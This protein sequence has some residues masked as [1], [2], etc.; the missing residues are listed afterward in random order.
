[1]DHVDV[2]IGV[3]GDAR[4]KA[5]EHY[6]KTSVLVDKMWLGLDAFK[7]FSNILKRQVIV[8]DLSGNT[9]DKEVPGKIVFDPVDGTSSDVPVGVAFRYD[10]HYDAVDNANSGTPALPPLVFEKVLAPSAGVTVAC[11]QVEHEKSTT[12]T[13]GASL[14]KVLD[15]VWPHLILRIAVPVPLPEL[16]VPFEDSTV[17]CTVVECALKTPARAVIRSCDDV[18]DAIPGLP[19]QVVPAVSPKR[20]AKNQKRKQRRIASAASLL[21]K[22]RLAVA[23]SEELALLQ[24]HRIPC[25]QIQA[26]VRRALTRTRLS[27]LR[28]AVTRTQT[29]FRRVKACTYVHNIREWRYELFRLPH[30]IKVQR[31]LRCKITLSLQ[32]RHASCIEIQSLTR[33]VLASLYLQKMICA[34]IRVQTL[35]RRIK[36]CAIVLSKRQR[37]HGCICKVQRFMR[38]KLYMLKMESLAIRMQAVVRGALFRKANGLSGNCTLAEVLS[39]FTP[40]DDTNVAQTLAL[41]HIFLRTQRMFSISKTL[42][43]RSISTPPSTN[44]TN[45]PEKDKHIRELKFLF[46]ELEDIVGKSSLL[47]RFD[48]MKYIRDV[49]SPDDMISSTYRKLMLKIHPDSLLGAFLRAGIR[50]MDQPLYN[51]NNVSSPNQILQDLCSALGMLRD[52]ALCVGFRADVET[53]HF[54]YITAVTTAVRTGVVSNCSS[55]SDICIHVARAVK[56]EA[57]V[58]VTNGILEIFEPLDLDTI[59]VATSTSMATALEPMLRV[60]RAGPAQFYYLRIFDSSIDIYLA[61]VS[62]ISIT[63]FNIITQS[64]TTVVIIDLGIKHLL[65]GGM[66]PA[67]REIAKCYKRPRLECPTAPL[68]AHQSSQPGD[69]IWLEWRNRDHFFGNHLCDNDNYDCDD[70][71]SF[72]HNVTDS[73][74]DNDNYDD[75]VDGDIMSNDDT[76]DMSDYDSPD[77]TEIPGEVPCP[78]SSESSSAPVTTGKVWEWAFSSDV[79]VSLKNVLDTVN[80]DIGTDNATVN[81]D[82]DDCVSAGTRVST[83]TYCNDDYSDG[84]DADSNYDAIGSDIGA[85]TVPTVNALI[86][87]SGVTVS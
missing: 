48:P 34:A 42:G 32:K 73:N 20:F 52:F 1:M 81:D 84:R 46:R 63:V 23:V 9:C 40:G 85:V 19:L 29:F 37:R 28:H 69:V 83:H 2:C 35:I 11:A 39:K 44:N 14:P 67:G 10:N 60:L 5:Y 65:R 55:S 43:R 13:G 78:F 3:V 12:V 30:I 80:D 87:G 64:H 45:I 70:S 16:L 24:T 72:N 51:G 50:N 61:C 86:A 41:S 49:A 18:V 58:H 26:L 59:D 82:K 54:L 71:D 56:C 17:P 76:F 79:K 62:Q 7:A 22:V 66:L 15:E 47:D 25:I 6:L 21:E 38:S 36:A 8:W 33:R 75:D 27:M 53:D 31:F 77:E 68:K 4:V 74:P 57:S